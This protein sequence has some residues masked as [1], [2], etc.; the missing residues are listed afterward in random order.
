[1]VLIVVIIESVS[2]TLPQ[3]SSTILNI[4]WNALIM[5][6]A[7]AFSLTDRLK[8]VEEDIY[9]KAAFLAI[10]VQTVQF[11]GLPATQF[12]LIS[13]LTDLVVNHINQAKLS[14]GKANKGVTTRN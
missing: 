12:S 1:M 5:L 4:L 13:Y 11:N 2:L 14:V 7:K 6:K 9:V 3:S 8:N 10:R